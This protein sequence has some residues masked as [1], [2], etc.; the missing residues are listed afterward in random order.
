MPEPNT[1]LPDPGMESHE[2]HSRITVA[3]VRFTLSTSE[4]WRLEPNIRT[5]GPFSVY[6]TSVSLS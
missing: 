6:V 3:E 5:G 2:R 1:V 4:I